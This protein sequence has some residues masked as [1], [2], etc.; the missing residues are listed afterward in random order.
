VSNDRG[1]GRPADDSVTLGGGGHG[2][3]GMRERV[4]LYQGS[5]DALETG[6]GGFTVRA[7][8]P[9]ER[10]PVPTGAIGGRR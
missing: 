7:N 8:L 4:E 6:D 2:L 9:V 10:Q 1:A 5:L 3:V